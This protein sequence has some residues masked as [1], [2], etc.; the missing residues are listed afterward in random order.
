[1]ITDV[2][3]LSFAS[4]D[5]RSYYGRFGM[6]FVYLIV[7]LRFVGFCVSLLFGCTIK[8]IIVL[9]PL[10][11]MMIGV[12][13]ICQKNCIGKITQNSIGKIRNIFAFRQ[14]ILIDYVLLGV[15][16]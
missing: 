14:R 4:S 6:R 1:M 11:E 3:R 13:G 12:H 5:R 2:Y 8:Q 10:V 9:H 15:C 16:Y 7:V